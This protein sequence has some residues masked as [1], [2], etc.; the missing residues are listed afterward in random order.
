MNP[1]SPIKVP[2]TS[3]GFN[4]FL[5]SGYAAT[6]PNY[7]FYGGEKKQRISKHAQDKTL[8]SLIVFFIINSSLSLFSSFCV[9]V[10]FFFSVSHF[11]FAV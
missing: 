5:S 6:S 8:L 4:T 3:C 7:A 1:F 9:F 2:P 10:S 11:I